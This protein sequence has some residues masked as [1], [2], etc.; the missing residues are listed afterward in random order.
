MSPRSPDPVDLG[1]RRRPRQARARATVE[2]LLATAPHLLE[3]VGLDGFNT[4]LLAERCGVP[5]RTVYRYFPNKLAVIRALAE[6]LAERWGAWF[7]DD[8][9]AD[10][11][12]DWRAAWRGYLDTFAAGIAREPGGL[13]IRAAL[14]AEPA[15]RAVEDQ[16]KRRLARRLTAALR[17]R[18]PHLSAPRAA[19]VARVLLQSAIAV[20]DDAFTGPARQRRALLD[21]LVA[22]HIAWLEEIFEANQGDG[23]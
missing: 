22:M 21:A 7:D 8:L 4:N 13:A 19:R 5:V 16:D 11:S 2:H 17:A 9:L 18:A 14:H 20:L 15:L 23:G 3:E 1:A 6:R 10:P 12:G